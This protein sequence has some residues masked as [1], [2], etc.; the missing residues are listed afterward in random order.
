[1][2]KNRKISKKLVPLAVAVVVAGAAA[3][4]KLSRIQSVSATTDAAYKTETVRKGTVSSGISES[5]TVTYGTTEQT[6]SVAEITEASLSSSDS[7]SDSSDSGS[8][9]NQSGTSAGSAAVNA[10]GGG[11]MDM[12]VMQGSD[13]G[14]A[15]AQAGSSQTSEQNSSSGST[16]SDSDTALVVEEVYAATGQVVAEGDPILKITDDSIAEYQAQLEAA[17]ETAQLNVKQEEINAESKKSEADYT[18]QMYL[19][20]GKTAE[21]TY[22]ATIASLESTVADLEEDLADAQDDVDTYQ[23][24][25]DCG[26]DYDDELEEA[27]DN[28]STIEANLQIAKNNLTTQSIEAKQTCESAMTNYKYADQL[29][30]IDTNGLEDDLNDAKETLEEAQEALADFQEQIG[31]GIVYATTSGTVTEVAYA[32]GD[33]ISNDATIVTYT[34]PE[35][36][37]ITV[38]VSQDDISSVSVGEEVSISLTA[39]PDDIFSGTV[40]GIATSA[41]AGSSTVNYD[42]TVLFSGDISKVYSGMTGEVTFAGKT[43]SDTLYISNQAVLLDGARTYVKVLEEDGSVREADVTTGYSNG[44][45]VAVESGLEE[46]E[47]ILIES[48]VES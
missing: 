18:Y 41:T 24:Y 46:G 6:F 38:S 33:E 2:N 28:Y 1:M 34:D 35:N 10:A 32:A 29:Y 39:Y 44:K 8:S 4:W 17:A 16:T 20:E 45:I 48:Q 3:G 30:E 22:Q 36:V 15:M 13:G 31:D 26:Y 47:T 37:T 43:V 12:A 27:Q 25:V 5:G 21:E 9:E 7:S 40:S 19:A 23:Y 14:D 11:S 42:V